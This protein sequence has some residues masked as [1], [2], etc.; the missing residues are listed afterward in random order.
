MIF[1]CHSSAVE[2]VRVGQ[3]SASGWEFGSEC[4]S[5]AVSGVPVVPDVG[6]TVPSV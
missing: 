5:V 6:G 4:V 2:V 1:M 3:M